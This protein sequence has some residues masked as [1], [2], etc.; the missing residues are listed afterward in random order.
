MRGSGTVSSG[1]CLSPQPSPHPNFGNAR[2]AVSIL[3]NIWKINCLHDIRTVVQVPG[4]TRDVTLRRGSE[5]DML[6]MLP[7]WCDWERLADFYS[8]VL[9]PGSETKILG[10][11]RR[12]DCCQDMHYAVIMI[13]ALEKTERS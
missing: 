11:S 10:H 1:S 12:P 8:E 6:A 4:P 3:P 2:L 9:D 7:C 5:V 13:A